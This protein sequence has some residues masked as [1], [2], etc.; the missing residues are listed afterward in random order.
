MKNNLIYAETFHT[1][2]DIK[3]WVYI[4]VTQ[5]LILKTHADWYD[6]R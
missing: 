4:I 3:N 6:H 5:V 1:L 2:L